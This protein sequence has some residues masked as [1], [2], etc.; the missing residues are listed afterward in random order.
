[1]FSATIN[2]LLLLSALVS[3]TF[4]QDVC[5]VTESGPLGPFY[6]SENIPVRNV[7]CVPSERPASWPEVDYSQ[8]RNIT[9]YGRVLGTDCEPID[10]SLVRLDAWHTGPFG[11]YDPITDSNA[12]C[13]AI[14][15]VSPEGEYN[16]TTTYPGSYP[17]RPIVHIHYRVEAFGYETLI[18]QN[19]FK[20]DPLYA[21]WGTDSP[22]W[23]DLDEDDA[24]NFDFYLQLI[25]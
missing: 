6:Q 20:D 23:L 15:P 11:E 5:E 9:I 19:Y 1:M 16:F 14:I 18:A 24:A 12:Y 7:I 13:R 25:Q 3:S 10:G 17:S 22:I 4:G 2:S 21:V 8:V